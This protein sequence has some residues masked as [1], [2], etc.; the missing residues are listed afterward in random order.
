MA[1]RGSLEPLRRLFPEPE[2][3][4]FADPFSVRLP[5]SKDKNPLL[6][7]FIAWDETSDEAT[8]LSPRELKAVVHNMAHPHH[9]QVA[10]HASPFQAGPLLSFISSFPS[11]HISFTITRCCNEDTHIEDAAFDAGLDAMDALCAA[12]RSDTGGRVRHLNVSFLDITDEVAATLAGA[13]ASVPSCGLRRLD[14]DFNELS[15][16]GA[17]ALV[18]TLLGRHL[19]MV[20]SL[21][22]MVG[23]SDAGRA[24]LMESVQGTNVSLIL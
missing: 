6:S 2:R 24:A 4:T 18:T 5:F 16:I 7:T 1:W 12:L 8:L 10:V 9:L 17:V 14:L 11:S 22:H 15:N 13:I 19:P 3:A 20:V 21:R 23:L